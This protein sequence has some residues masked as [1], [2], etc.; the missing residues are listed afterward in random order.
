MHLF[1]SDDQIVIF[2]T[3]HYNDTPEV[4]IEKAERP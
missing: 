1:D 4:A 3:F 2:R